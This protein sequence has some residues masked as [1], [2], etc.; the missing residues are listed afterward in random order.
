MTSMA[1][2]L[3]VGALCTHL[4]HRRAGTGNI[5]QESPLKRA[6]LLGG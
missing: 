6:F 5:T 2:T 1:F 4:H 3:W